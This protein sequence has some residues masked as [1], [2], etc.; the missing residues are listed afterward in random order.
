MISYV[1]LTYFIL[2]SICFILITIME[3]VGL[4]IGIVGLA[5]QLAKVSQEWSNMFSEMKE[6]G[7]AHDSVLHD[8]RTEGFRLKRW[9]KTWGLDGTSSQQNHY[10]N[11]NDERYGLQ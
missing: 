3:A 1:E 4:A 6:I 2:N 10:L 8:L 9:E 11:P 7:Y 5:G